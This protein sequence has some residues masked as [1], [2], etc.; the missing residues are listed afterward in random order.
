M[1]RPA[2][3]HGPRAPTHTRRI[4][5]RNLSKSHR[6]AGAEEPNAARAPGLSRFL[7]EAPRQEAALSGAPLARVGEVLPEAQLVVS[8]WGE[9]MDKRRHDPAVTLS[10]MA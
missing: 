9:G 10:M 8:P 6:D 3:T 5:T 7:V 4:P 2:P 1:G